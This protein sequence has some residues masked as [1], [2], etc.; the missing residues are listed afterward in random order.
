MWILL[1][2]SCIYIAVIFNLYI[3][4][5]ILQ[6]PCMTRS[7]SSFMHESSH[8]LALNAVIFTWIMYESDIESLYQAHFGKMKL[9]HIIIPQL[10]SFI[11]VVFLSCMVQNLAVLMH[12]LRVH[13]NQ[14]LPQP[15]EL[16]DL[17]C[18][19]ELTLPEHIFFN[20]CFILFLDCKKLS[21]LTPY[22]EH[23]SLK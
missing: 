5:K 9:Q 17:L 18:K 21:P 20:S 23:L 2:C 19:T 3:N 8:H 4:V 10:Y 1:H 12:V 22:S 6:E 7:V 14:N 15:S 13:N 11:R 16:A